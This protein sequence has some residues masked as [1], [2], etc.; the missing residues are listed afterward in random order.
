MQFRA[1]LAHWCF[2]FEFKPL[3][4]CHQDYPCLSLRV[5]LA[6]SRSAI[7]SLVC[8]LSRCSTLTRQPRFLCPA[9]LLSAVIVFSI[10]LGYLGTLKMPGKWMGELACV[11]PLFNSAI[12]SAVIAKNLRI[13]LAEQSFSRRTISRPECCSTQSNNDIKSARCGDADA[14]IRD[15]A[16]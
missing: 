11:K 16:R 2:R 4:L 1:L 3:K 8:L 12:R 9:V 13:R 6:P 15:P 5:A 14:R 10:P 7:L